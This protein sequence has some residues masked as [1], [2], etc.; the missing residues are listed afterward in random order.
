MSVMDE[1]FQE[2]IRTTQKL[3]D[4]DAKIKEIIQKNQLLW[5]KIKNYDTSKLIEELQHKWNKRN[6]L[7]QEE[8][9]KLCLLM[10]AY[11]LRGLDVEYFTAGAGASSGNGE[12]NCTIL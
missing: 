4:T 7:S 9:E 1:I 6:K 2:R 10:L 12:S 8:G 3:I 5:A 11:R